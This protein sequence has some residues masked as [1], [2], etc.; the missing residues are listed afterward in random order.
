[1]KYCFENNLNF[2]VLINSIKEAI[3]SNSLG[4]KY[5]ICSKEFAEEVTKTKYF[6]NKV[7]FFKRRNS[8]ALPI[9]IG[10]HKFGT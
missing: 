8:K 10:Q 4:A 6:T 2:A 7:Y 5:I 3:Y 9:K 1:M